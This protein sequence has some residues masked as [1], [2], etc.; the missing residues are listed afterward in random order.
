MVTLG[1][2]WTRRTPAAVV[3]YAGLTAL[4]ATLVYLNPF[5]GFFAWSGYLEASCLPG[6]WRWAGVTATATIVSSTYVGGFQKIG[7]ATLPQ[8]AIFTLAGVVLGGTFMFFGSMVGRQNA[9]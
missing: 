3:Y 8:F 7:S 4:S 1:P 9:E 5:Y 6:R 2:A